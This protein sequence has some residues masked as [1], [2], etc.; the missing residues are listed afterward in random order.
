[1]VAEHADPVAVAGFTAA[2]TQRVLP[3]PVQ[4]LAYT[5]LTPFGVPVSRPAPSNGQS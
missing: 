5:V 4:R 3:A 2:A 1:M